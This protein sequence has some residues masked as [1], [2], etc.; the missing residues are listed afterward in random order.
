[1]LYIHLFGHLRLLLDG[2]PYRFQGLPKTT[3]LLAYLLLHRDTAVFRDHLAFLLWDDVPETEARANL[4]R[5]LHDLRSALPPD[6]DWIQ[7]AGRNIQW[8]PA[9]PVWLDV[10]EFESLCQSVDH[11]AEAV[12]LYTGDL[13]QTLYEDWIVLER[14]RLQALYFSTLEKLIAREHKRGDLVQAMAYARQLLSRD[15]L[16]EDVLRD[17]MLLRVENGDRA[18]ALQLYQQFKERL[19]EEL[20][21]APMPETTAVYEQITENRPL[22]TAA[23]SPVL[24]QAASM[25]HDS[26]STAPSHPAVPAP[27]HNLPAPLTS[28]V[29][30][31]EERSQICQLIGKTNSPVRLLTITGSGGTGKT[32]LSIEVALWL[33]QN[34]PEQFPDGFY[35]VGL[36][37]VTN[38][39][40]VLPAI[41]ETLDI[42]S[43]ADLSLFD[44]LKASLRGK[45]LLL[46]LDNFEHLL[47]AAPQVADLLTAVP[48][49]HILITSQSVLHLYGEHEF[50]LLP[51]PLPTSAHLSP[52]DLL[53]YAAIHLFVDRLRAV[54]PHFLLTDENSTA[55]TEICR[56][57]DGMPLALELAAAR[58]KLFTPAAMLTQLSQRLRFLT[59]QARNLPARHQ[60]LRATI[61]WSYNLL[62]IAEQTV[63]AGLSLFAGS[64]TM[65]AGEAILSDLHSEESIQNHLFSLADKNMLRALPAADTTELRFRMLQ[66]LREYGLGKLAQL[67]TAAAIHRRYAV[68]YA[69]LAEQGKAGM[70]SADQSTWVQQ[71]RQEDNNLIAALELLVADPDTAQN[72]TTMI[73]LLTSI[74]RFW[75]L[76][77]RIRDLRYWLERALVYLPVLPAS[78]QAALLNELGN[79]AQVQGDYATAEDCHRQALTLA[80][81]LQDLSL[82]AYTLHFLAYAAGRQ[83]Q[84]IEAKTLFQESLALHRQLPETTPLQLTTLL[85]NLAI[86]HRR[87]DEYDEAIAL[88]QET[89]AVKRAIGDRLGLPSPLSNLGNLFILQ[90]KLAEATTYLREALELRQEIQDRQGLLYSLNQMAAL[91]TAQ[92]QYDRAA[93]LYA[94]ADARHQDMGISRTA[95]DAEDQQRDMDIVR[96]QINAAILQ[97]CEAAGARMTL[98]DAVAYAL[99]TSVTL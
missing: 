77:G 64:F 9:A 37:A 59:G 54:Q 12:T 76:Q 31:Q 2:N 68:Y 66:T 78:L 95:D 92:K 17:Y 85:N 48:G 36:S 61:D 71:L 39:D 58:G 79:T 19:I 87:L 34:H 93:T 67:E 14:E 32:R 18:G 50:T 20:G 47:D 35:F 7:S 65:T 99:Q 88:L 42:R 29:G 30:R 40:L 86:V 98:A 10:A 4:R 55:V 6:V 51:L 75:L 43:R 28:F 97:E 44:N 27:A 21:I 5:H 16:R 52:A 26:L 11:L 13:L 63:F 60:T 57:L 91:A 74:A 73:R 80:R 46:L 8:N 15:P 82:I 84:Y 38:P 41:V 94:A 70:R 72:A 83:G 45:R 96:Q 62:T 89:L 90:G 23:K 33:R 53:N 3:P 22:S 81:E 25:L 56:C 1:M 49:L 24:P 69:D